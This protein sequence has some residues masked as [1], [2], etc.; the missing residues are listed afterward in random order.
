MAEEIEISPELK[1]LIVELDEEDPKSKIDALEGMWRLQDPTAIQFLV[2]IYKEEDAYSEEVRAKAAEILGKYKGLAT[3]RSS[4][5]SKKRSTKRRSGAGIR[6]LLTVTLLLFAILNIGLFVMSNSEDSDSDAPASTSPAEQRMALLDQMSQDMT[7]TETI[8]RDL[9][10]RA[11]DYD[12]GLQS[13]DDL[14]AEPV[15]AAPTPVE[16]SEAETE[17]FPDVADLASR[18]TGDYRFAIAGLNAALGLWTSGCQSE[19]RILDSSGLID[20]T[21][22]TIDAA[23]AAQQN[24]LATLLAVVFETPTPSPVPTSTMEPTPEPTPT[25]T[26]RER[27]EIVETILVQPQRI[28]ADTQEI[29][30]RIS[31]IDNGAR[32]SEQ[33]DAAVFWNPP[34]VILNAEEAGLYPDI[35]AFGENETSAFNTALA[36][37]EELKTNWRN[38]CDSGNA[39]AATIQ[40]IDILGER[41]INRVPLAEAEVNTAFGASE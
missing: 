23:R 41:V 11:I 37:L 17:L 24:D 26:A 15:D 21:V 19:D 38:V 20:R 7:Q 12:D 39:S 13:L 27:G 40:T 35:Q 9:R 28:Q 14:C 32:V 22:T 16:L 18:P 10:S 5:K 34:G 3:S 36:S 30:N 31:A 1:A 2:I 25:P 8:A 33:C 6:R 4:G 29:L